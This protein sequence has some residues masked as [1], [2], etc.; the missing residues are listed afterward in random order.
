MSQKLKE[1]RDEIESLT[2]KARGIEH[3]R[4]S[5]MLQKHVG[6]YYKERGYF[7]VYHVQK[8]CGTVLVGEK[9]GASLG[10]SI[11]VESREPVVVGYEFTEITKQEYWAV[12]DSLMKEALLV[13]K[14]N[15][16]TP[17]QWSKKLKRIFN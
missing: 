16:K 12:V 10:G 7:H 2:K 5:R 14:G 8:R 13:G 15:P 9:V 4:T 3:R 1:L 11:I 6:K 17:E